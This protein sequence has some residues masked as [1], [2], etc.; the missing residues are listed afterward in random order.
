MH[1]LRLRL[2][3]SAFAI[4]RLPP[5]APLPDGFALDRPWHSATRTRAELSLIAPTRALPAALPPEAR[6]EEPYRAFE[7]AG[8]LDFSLVG[9]LAE[10][11]AALADARIPV[12]VVSTFDTDTLFVREERVEE[13]WRTLRAAGHALEREEDL[14]E[15]G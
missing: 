6:V 15:S 13:A 14:S 3:R 9:I 7:V 12:F 5:D 2:S 10:L 8:P 4:V 11:T 1:E